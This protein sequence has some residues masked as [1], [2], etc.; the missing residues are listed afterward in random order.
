MTRKFDYSFLKNNIPANLFGL[1]SIISDLR[2]KENIRKQQYESTFKALQRKAVIES[3]KSSNAIEGIVATDDRIHDIIN[4]SSP[5]T[6]D[7]KEISGYRD[8]LNL[9]HTQESS[10]DVNLETI[11]LFH[12]MIQ[13]ETEPNEAGH[14]KTR[15]NLIMDFLPDGSRCVRFRPV[16][17]VE[18][19]DAMDQMILAY[20]DARQD[21]SI[22]P[23]LL[24]P[25]VILDF[26]C[27][28]PFLDGNGRVSRLLTVLLLYLSG[29][30]IVRY[31]SLEKQVDAYKEAYYDALRDSSQGWHENQN[32]YT[33]FIVNFLQILYHCYKS[34]DES[35]TDISIQKAKKN[36]RVE[37]V[38]ENAIVPISK[39]QIREKLPDVSVKTIE[40]VLG[41]LLKEGKIQKIGTY[42]NARYIKS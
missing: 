37:A 20:Y 36:E 30:D 38:L 33:P 21:S 26:L 22:P 12:R 3:V 4:G 42:K 8:A 11:C 27:I 31:I 2:A 29:Y 6:H 14:Y 39:S 41:N 5:V 23:L 13:E 18:T 1:A 35:F 16:K 25:C 15:D 7:E 28:H 34:L 24:I 9:I 32:D 40:L 17:A 19:A 10:L